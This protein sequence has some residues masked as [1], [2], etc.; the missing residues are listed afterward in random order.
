MAEKFF[1]SR[2]HGVLSLADSNDGHGFPISYG[3]DLEME[4]CIIQFVLDSASHKQQSHKQQ[5]H[6][7]QSHKQQFLE[8]SNTV[9][10]TTYEYAADGT[11]QSAIATGSL[12]PL[13]SEAVANWA[14]AIF[15]TNAAYVET[16]VR[17]DST[18][19]EIKWYELEI[20]SLTGRENLSD[21]RSETKLEPELEQ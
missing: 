20:E 4:H 16:P 9:T 2:G 1:A 17:Q 6:K 3:Y 12:V 14:A 21:G 10:L 18:D 7:Q 13:S 11:W 19:T 8:A 15:F 5:S